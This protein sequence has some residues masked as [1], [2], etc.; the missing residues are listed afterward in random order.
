MQIMQ[1]TDK[2]ARVSKLIGTI[3]ILLYD[4][5]NHLVLNFLQL[6]FII[7]IKKMMDLPDYRIHLTWHHV[8]FVLIFHFFN[9]TRA[10]KSF[11]VFH[12]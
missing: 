8:I 10:L 1:F 2:S 12:L 6:N 9:S 3:R 11:R 4:F 7:N 5:M